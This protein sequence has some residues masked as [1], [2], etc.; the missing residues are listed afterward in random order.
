MFL[1]RS[2][3]YHDVN[4]AFKKK[5]TMFK[6]VPT[7]SS[8][9]KNNV[10]SKLP[11]LPVKW[12]FF[13]LPL[14]IVLTI[15]AS[16]RFLHA[17]YKGPMQTL[18]ESYRRSGIIDDYGLYPDFNPDIT[19][20]DRRCNSADITTSDSNDLIVAPNA[21]KDEAADIMLTHGAV[22]IQNLLSKETATELR[23]YLE[24]RNVIKDQL[25]WHE[26][27]WGD[28]GRLSLGLGVD[29]ANIIGQALEEVGSNPTLRTVLEGI[30][31]PD[32][33]IVE[34]STL[35]TMHG[36]EMQ[37]IHTDSDFFGSSLMFSRTFLHSYTLFMALQ[38][39][40]SKM[41]ATTVCP[42]THWCSD[43]DLSDVCLPG[44][45]EEPH[46]FEV[47][48]NG[49]TGLETGMLY[50]GDGMMFNQNIW[51]R[52]PRN[53]DPEWPI[54]RVMFILTFVSRQDHNKGDVRQQ[55]LGT[56]YYQR[57]NMWGHTFEDLKRAKKIMT[58]P[59][60]ALRALGIWKL[61]GTKWG[62]P[63]FEHFARQLANN[64]DFF[65]T[66]ELPDFLEFLDSVGVPKWIQGRNEKSGRDDKVLQWEPFLMQLMENVTH[67][68]DR[69]HLMVIGLYV[70][71]HVLFIAI[72]RRGAGS[73]VKHTI[74]KYLITALFGMIVWYY[75]TEVSH[76]G[77]R[78]K[79]RD[80]WRQPFSNSSL[81]HLEHTTFPTRHDVL[82]GSRFDA[83][84]LASFNHVLDYHPGNKRFAKAMKAFDSPE[85]IHAFLSQPIDGVTPRFLQQDWQ[86]GYWSLITPRESDDYIQKQLYAKHHPLTARLDEQLKVN[87]ADARFG[88]NRDKV[89]S[90][91]FT[92]QL[93]L[94][95]QKML[96]RNVKG[97]TTENNT[98]MYTTKVKKQSR[99]RIFFQSFAVIPMRQKISHKSPSI[100]HFRNTDGSLRLV[101]EG[102]Q[103]FAPLSWSGQHAEA[104]ILRGISG[105]SV[106]V[107]YTFS[108]EI[109]AVS[110][111]DIRP[112]KSFVQG[113]RVA[114]LND[115]TTGQWLW[116]DI[117][118]IHPLG[119]VSVLCIDDAGIEHLVKRIPFNRIRYVDEP[120]QALKVL[121]RIDK[122]SKG[123][124]VKARYDENNWFPATIAEI[125]ADGTFGVIYDDG[126]SETNVPGQF[127]MSMSNNN[128]PSVI[129]SV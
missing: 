32:P 109:A 27:F 94:A 65:T 99:T 85:W 44:T 125:N 77:N 26:K 128:K 33:A 63:W 79:M 18:I 15:W 104:K 8:S 101:R 12:V 123:E 30:V 118:M 105:G 50:Q 28:I 42:G 110:I 10:E 2:D 76:L 16:T 116:G 35:T 111:V 53:L 17:F 48:S 5:N 112:F 34:I 95:L 22:M 36:A 96:Y 23:A 45:D 87:L 89:L 6:V 98:P 24:T 93:V 70:I 120:A 57:W 100:L 121:A 124:R 21:T 54:N 129:A 4:A 71:F 113:D 14:W 29:D 84:Y 40:T 78:I 59:L 9:S 56:Y 106:L 103:V 39:T 86:T 64:E 72:T 41:G 51:H 25:P 73:F 82:L 102:D 80:T 7:I 126:E 3:F 11:L 47:S 115:V 49:Q 62:I 97:A 1:E 61:P 20:Y 107:K 127:L 46:A 83:P 66:Y 90:S 74:L 114:I 52:G 68:V 75:V 92:V 81:E 88:L 91:K 31:G 19:Y 60:A 119:Y 13:H 37:D 55:G 67:F 69:I 122:F 117:I 108:D 43:E 58:Q 38:D